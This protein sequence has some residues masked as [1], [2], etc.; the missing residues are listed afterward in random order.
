MTTVVL[1]YQRTSMPIYTIKG[2]TAEAYALYEVDTETGK[3]QK[4]REIRPEQGVYREMPAGG[5]RRSHGKPHDQ[6]FVLKAL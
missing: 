2:L 5:F 4:V 6:L 3:R 1:Y